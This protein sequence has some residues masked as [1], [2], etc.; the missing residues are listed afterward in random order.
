MI[1]QARLWSRSWRINNLLVGPSELALG[2]NIGGGLRPY[3]Q[4]YLD[5]SKI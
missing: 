4:F 3:V 5:Q 1:S 2:P